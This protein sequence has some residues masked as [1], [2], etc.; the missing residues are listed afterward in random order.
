MSPTLTARA[1]LFVVQ[2]GIALYWIYG[3]M[4]A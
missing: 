2:L 1:T 3:I 4:S